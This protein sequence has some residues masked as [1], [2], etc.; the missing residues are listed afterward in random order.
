ML[1]PRYIHYARANLKW[2]VLGAFCGLVAGLSSGFGVP[3]FIQQVFRK[4]FEDSDTRYTFLHLLGVAALLPGIFLVRGASA[5]ANQ[6]VLQYVGQDILLRLRARLFA[7]IQ[8]LPVPWFERRQSGDLIAKLVGDTLVVQEA[9]LV[10]AKEA[11]VQPFTFLAGFGFLVYLSAQQN[12]FGFILLLLILAPLMAVPVRYIGRHLRKRSRE[13]QETLGRLTEIMAE[14]LRGVIEVRAFNLQR[15]ETTRFDER[16]RA[17]NRFA[18]KMA[19]YYH[20]TQPLMELIA[21]S[22]VSLAFLYSYERRIEFSTFAALGAALYFSVDAIKA[23]LKMVNGV[24]RAAGS[25]ARIEQVLAEKETVTDPPT[26]APL[27]VPLRGEIRFD[28]VSFAYGDQPALRDIDVTIPAGT[29]CAL[30]GPSGAGKS[31]F[32]KLIPRFYDPVAG[33]I[34]LDGADIATVRKAELRSHIAFVPQQPVLFNGT[35][36]E[37]IAIARPDAGHAAIEAAARAA[38]AHDFISALEHG[39]ATEVGE[40]AVR[41]SGGQRQRLALA[42]AFLTGARVLILD[43]ATSALDAESEQRIQQALITYAANRTVLIIAHRFATIRLAGRILLFDDG[44]VVNQG[45]YAALLA[46]PLFARLAGGI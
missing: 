37:N 11:F 23:L 19:K 42:R 4:I 35:V 8:A 21:V 26:P 20:V 36:G 14:N 18:M 13:L 5:Y 40:N 34:L 46:D 31:T 12:E 1:P 41:L 24:Q 2:L 15:R 38:H 39:Y 10:V 17:Y 6:Y 22:M 25:F 3:F 9:M 27:P 7:K 43:E 33:R 44:R 28:Q 32:A 29:I 30:V 45:S 16:L